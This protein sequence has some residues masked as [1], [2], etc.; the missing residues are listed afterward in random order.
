M[1][2]VSVRLANAF[3]TTTHT[4]SVSQ[5]DNKQQTLLE[6]KMM[7]S[8]FISFLLL[9]SAIAGQSSQSTNRHPL[10]GVSTRQRRIHR[11][12][13]SWAI[14]HRSKPNVRT[15]A[16]TK[17]IDGM[18][19]VV[20]VFRPTKERIA[21]WFG[22]EEDPDQLLRCMLRKEFNH[23]SVGM[24]NPFL[25]FE[26]DQNG[27]DPLL[28]SVQND[29]LQITVPASTNDSATAN[30]W[31][32]SLSFS[33]IRKKEWRVLTHRRR[34]GQGRG[35]Y[36]RVRDAALDWEFQSPDGLLG[37]LAIPSSSFLQHATKQRSTPNLR[38]RGSYS[39]R[40]IPTGNVDEPM[41]FHRRIGSFRR[42]V[43]YSASKLPLLR[44]I[45]VVNPVMVVYD[46][47]D[48]R[49]VEI[50]CYMLISLLLLAGLTIFFFCF[51][52]IQCTRHNFYIHRICYHE[53]TLTTRGRTCDCSFER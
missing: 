38:Y 51:G 11:T 44:K 50:I 42:M 4:R 36:E 32:P 1:N 29:N 30:T 53:G 28:L 26:N 35:C 19:S 13:Q 45:Y 10:N 22:L 40:S 9:F 27:E 52:S 14:R 33:P 39:V 2:T 47:V 41:A 21:K 15:S 37:M 25:H 8:L 3:L 34:V 31:W 48:Q 20:T 7:L 43:S 5:Q 46:L 24:T 23:D 17:M 12:L 6:L 16:P 49:C 18:G